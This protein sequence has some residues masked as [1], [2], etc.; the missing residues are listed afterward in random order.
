VYA[1]IRNRPVKIDRQRRMASRG[2]QGE[3]DFGPLN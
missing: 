2:S 1:W 3:P